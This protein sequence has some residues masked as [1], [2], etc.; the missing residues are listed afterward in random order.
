M[1]KKGNTPWNRGKTGTAAG[2]TEARRERISLAMTGH[3]G[4]RPHLWRQGPDPAVRR[5]RYRYLRSKAQAKYL[6]QAWTIDWT[7]YRELLGKVRGQYG[8]GMTQ[9]NL[10]R[11]DCKDGWHTWNVHLIS[12]KEAMNRPREQQDMNRKY[13]R[14]LTR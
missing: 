10:A 8:R 4:P 1:F 9:L 6:G 11:K 13:R 3:R 14:Q 12:R 5:D 7:Q 2:W